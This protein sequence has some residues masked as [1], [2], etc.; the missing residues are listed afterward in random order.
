[1]PASTF[2][3]RS[4]RLVIERAHECCEYCLLYQDN[5]PDTHHIDH[6]IAV[7][8]GGQTV[9]GRILAY[10]CAECNLY[11]RELI[12]PRL[13]RRQARL[14][15][16]SIRARKHG[17]SIFEFNEAWITGLTVMDDAQF[18][19]HIDHVIAVKASFSSRS[20]R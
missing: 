10:V 2:H 9:R 4:G 19:H 15:R 7:K 6:V 16:S 18:A 13:I 20:R 11:K 17:T 5:S 3:H 12:S 8:H 14:F 1:M